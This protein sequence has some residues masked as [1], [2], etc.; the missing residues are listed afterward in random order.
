[1][2]LHVGDEWS[3]AST[4]DFDQLSHCA[5]WVSLMAQVVKYNGDIPCLELID[6]TGQTV[7]DHANR[8]FPRCCEPYKSKARCKTFHMK[9]SF[10][11]K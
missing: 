2:S 7:R 8:P 11:C 3:K 4:D 1:M 6:T 10:V 9:I 5:Q